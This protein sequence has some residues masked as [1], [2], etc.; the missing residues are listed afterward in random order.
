MTEHL[1]EE[2]RFAGTDADRH[3]VTLTGHLGLQ[4]KIETGPTGY[5]YIRVWDQP[6]EDARLHVADARAFRDWLNKV[7]P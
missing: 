5:E 1:S 6:G 7:L 3:T 4:C 2:K